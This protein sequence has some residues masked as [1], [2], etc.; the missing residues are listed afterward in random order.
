LELYT[1]ESYCVRPQFGRI[2]GDVGG[3]FPVQTGHHTQHTQ[4]F[5]NG[6]SHTTAH[7]A[8]KHTADLLAV[9]VSMAFLVASSQLAFCSAAMMA[10]FPVGVSSSSALKEVRKKGRSSRCKH[11]A[12]HYITAN[13]TLKQ[14]ATDMA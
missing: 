6:I 7:T 1:A 3:K 14:T 10:A 5:T 8:H 11:T 12:T 9:Y 4:H 13:T 2:L